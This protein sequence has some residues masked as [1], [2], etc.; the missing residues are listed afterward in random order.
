MSLSSQMVIKMKFTE[1][2]GRFFW[3]FHRVLIRKHLHK[4]C[5]KCAISE[6]YAQ[7]EK[8]TGVC[9]ICS[10][11]INLSSPSMDSHSFEMLENEL[12]LLLQR[13]ERSSKGE[14]DALVLFSG[15]K[16]SAYLVYEL[17]QRH[18]GLRLLCLLID[19][20]FM[21]PTALYNASQAAEKLN[22]DYV[23]YRPC[24]SFYKKYFR[25][26]CV[27]PS[28]IHRGCFETIDMVELYFF[29]SIA[30][31]FAARN[32]IPL[33]ID[34]LAWAQV[35]RFYEVKSFETPLDLE[36]HK[37]EKE[38]GSFLTGNKEASHEKYFWYPDKFQPEQIPRLIH[39]FYIWRHKEGDVR[40]K[41]SELGLINKGYDSPLITN[42]QVIVMM[43]IVDYIR[44]G[45]CSYEPDIT[46]QI[47]EGTADRHYWQ[48]IFEMSEYI[49]KTGWMMK[50]EIGKIAASLDLTLQDLD[51]KW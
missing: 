8:S 23:A 40:K 50:K 29:Y 14:Y 16:D 33:I 11:K 13:H 4:R 46:L 15:G 12:K 44:L 21:S 22:V 25:A 10:E 42:Q 45:Y 1:W 9:R 31:T 32:N 49:A 20:G 27:D 5:S 18:P 28:V 34:G 35:E 48:A 43:V 47:R 26:A 38:L 37:V 7:L 2:Y 3:P 19:N 39:P 6:A 30:K 51:L 41:V 24:K 36:I 17:Q